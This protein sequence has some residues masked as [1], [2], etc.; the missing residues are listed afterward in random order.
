MIEAVTGLRRRWRVVVSVFIVC[1]GLS[2]LITQQTTPVYESDTQLFIALGNADSSASRLQSGV[3]FATSRVKSYPDLVKSPLVLDPVIKSLDLPVDATRLARDVSAEVAPNTVLMTVRVD[4]TDPTLAANIAN[5]VAENLVPLIERLD[6][7]Q[8]AQGQ[9]PVR[10]TVVRPAVAPS[11]ASSPLPVLNLTIGALLGLIL[12]IGGALLREALDTSVKTTA[13]VE[14]VS[15]LPTI[16]AIPTGPKTGDVPLVDVQGSSPWSE[17]Y[18]K[19][20]TN[21]SYLDPD[22]PPRSLIITSAKPG[23]GKTLTS[24]NLAASMAKNNRRAVLVEADLRRPTVSRVLGL[25]P[26]VGVTNVVAGKAAI[27]EVIQ[28]ASGFDVIASGPIPPNPSEL[29]GSHAF[30]KLIQDL[31]L[32]YDTIIIDSPPLLAVTDAAVASVHADGVVL[33]CSAGRTRRQELRRALESLRPVE[34]NVLGVVLNRVKPTAGTY[35][36]Y[37]YEYRRTRK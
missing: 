16:G 3:F 13:D 21:L 2:A 31:A 5:A 36:D 33:V 35:Y 11:S 32:D 10:A 8:G 30:G 9:A 28:H 25:V 1:V 18:R 15:E 19:L 7:A 22:N 20:R 23:E 24:V 4:W 26:D 17:S 6:A 34:A 27:S 14:E 12:G 29:L 37:S